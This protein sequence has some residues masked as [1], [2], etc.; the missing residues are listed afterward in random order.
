[1]LSASTI[2]LLSLLGAIATLDIASIMVRFY[3]NCC[4]KPKA[5]PVVDLPWEEFE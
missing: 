4:N 1:M 5:P 3:G 2:A